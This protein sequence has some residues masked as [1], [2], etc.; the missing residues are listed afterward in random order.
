[1]NVSLRALESMKRQVDSARRRVSTVKAEA[2]EA[3]EVVVAAAEVSGTAFGLGIINGRWGSPEV[4]GVPVDAGVGIAAHV[5]AFMDIAPEHL[6]NV[7]NGGL[8]SYFSALGV[9]VGQKM[10]RE[11]RQPIQP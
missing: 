5:F 10:A 3:V 2:E 7:G 1:V 6:H 9:G 8:G 11:S 4:L